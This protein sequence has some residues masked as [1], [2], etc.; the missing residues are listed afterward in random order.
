MRLVLAGRIVGAWA[1]LLESECA[2]SLRSGR[3]V[4]LDV[5]GV[6]FIGRSGFESLGRLSRAGAVIVGGSRLLAAMLEQ[7]GIAVGRTS[8]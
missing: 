8:Q 3:R 1:G 7:E 6:V 4:V 2:E 5:S